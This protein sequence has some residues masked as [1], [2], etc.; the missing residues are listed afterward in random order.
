MSGLD[1]GA[2]IKKQRMKEVAVRASGRT[3]MTRNRSS[4]AEGKCSLRWKVANLGEGVSLEA[5]FISSLS[6]AM[7]ACSVLE[8]MR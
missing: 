7:L 1:L 6:E 2:G 8:L 5:R 4:S 3:K